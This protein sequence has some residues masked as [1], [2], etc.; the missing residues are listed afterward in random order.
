MSR[1]LIMA[2]NESPQATPFRI[3][4]HY[5]SDLQAAEHARTTA[6]LYARKSNQAR[7]YYALKVYR[8][9]W[10]KLLWFPIWPK[11]IPI[12]LK[13]NQSTVRHQT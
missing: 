1:Y 6:L 9:E 10:I 8:I 7:A 4:R 3:T 13:T 12:P 11:K 2:S 5:A